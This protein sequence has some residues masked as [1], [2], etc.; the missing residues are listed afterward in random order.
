ML[1]GKLK[2]YLILC[3]CV[4]ILVMNFKVACNK[5]TKSLRM[6][7]K[8]PKKRDRRLDPSRVSSEESKF[9]VFGFFFP[10]FARDV[11]IFI[12]EKFV[13]CWDNF[14]FAYC[15]LFYSFYDSC[16]YYFIFLVLFIN[17]RKITWSR[18]TLSCGAS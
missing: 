1:Y 5:G 12:Q 3:T 17:C 11:S 16:G 13:A 18:L 7:C 15:Y 4:C 9:G 8:V 14:Y 10:F 6:R 2:S